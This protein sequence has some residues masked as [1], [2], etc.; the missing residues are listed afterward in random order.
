MTS[1]VEGGVDM[2]KRVLTVR[3]E[4]EGLRLDVFLA[5]KLDKLTRSYIQDLI[6]SGHVFVNTNKKLKSSYRIKSNDIIDI[7]IPPPKTIEILEEDIPLNILYEDE[8]IAII[9]KPKGMIVHPTSGNYSGTLVNSLLYHFDRL[10][11][12]AGIFR[13]GIIH[14]LDKDT[15]GLLIIAKTDDAHRILSKDF[16]ARKIT[17]IYWAIVERNIREDEGT[18]DTLIARHPIDRKKM[19]VVNSKSSRRAITHFKVLERFEDYTLVQLELQTGRTHQLRV[20]MAYIGNPIVGDTLYGSKIQKF[21]T[22]GQV[23]HAKRL[24]FIHPR[25]G[26]YMEFEGELPEYFARLVEI[27]Q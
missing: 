9:D 13:P 7:T 26:E 24:A 19:A 5:D 27:L 15:S 6:S 14:R 22:Q 3:D 1:M 21:K 20:H 8:D 11:S 18:I 23:L 25:T 17:R 2:Q 10:S 16:K 12:V 4:E